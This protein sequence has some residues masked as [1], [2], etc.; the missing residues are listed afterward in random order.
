MA[1]SLAD[2]QFVRPPPQPVVGVVPRGRKTD[3][4]ENRT[5]PLVPCKPRAWG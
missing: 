3:G 2:V 1:L 4:M 5:V